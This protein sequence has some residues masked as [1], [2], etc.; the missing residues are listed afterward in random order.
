MDGSPLLEFTQEDY[1]DDNVGPLVYAIEETIEKFKVDLS[2][3][4]V[5]VATVTGLNAIEASMVVEWASFVVGRALSNVDVDGSV[6]MKCFLSSEGSRKT[7]M[8]QL[9]RV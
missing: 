5:S 8:V 9:T 3:M 1:K 6:D 7:L 2:D 4:R